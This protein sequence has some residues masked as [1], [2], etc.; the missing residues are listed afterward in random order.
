M[1]DW[2]ICE[3]THCRAGWAITL[4]GQAGLILQYIYGASAAGAMIYAASYPELPVPD[5][6]CS[7]EEAMADMKARA[8]LG[9]DG[10]GVVA[11]QE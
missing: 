2:H 10:G 3:T 11:T 9:K 7:D 4:A 6:Y 5:F 1:S 8:V